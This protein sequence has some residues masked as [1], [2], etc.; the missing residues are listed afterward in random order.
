MKKRNLYLKLRKN[1]DIDFRLRCNLRI[2]M[3]KVLK[4]ISKSAS[5]MKLIGCSIKKLK[6]HLSNQFIDNMSW[7][8]YGDWE[9]DHIRPCS[10][11]DLS[12]KS[13]QF[14]CFNYN[15]LRPLWAIDNQIKGAKYV[16]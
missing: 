14:K 2:R 3:W 5:T 10:S 8:N 11:F 12:K 6:Y 16:H 9:V 4:G 13:E 1:N 7:L 15:N